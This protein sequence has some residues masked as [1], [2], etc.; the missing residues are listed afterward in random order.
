MADRPQQGGRVAL[1]LQLLDAL[2]ALA[3]HASPPSQQPI[4]WDE[5]FVIAAGER[6]TFAP[7]MGTLVTMRK[8]RRRS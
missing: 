8:Q 5:R 1:L 2:A 3:A 4:S 6:D 7:T